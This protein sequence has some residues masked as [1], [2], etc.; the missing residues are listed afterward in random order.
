MAFRAQEVKSLREY[1]PNQSEATVYLTV[2]L[3]PR[4]AGSLFAVL[5]VF[6]PR[7]RS[8]R[9]D[10]LLE[11]WARKQNTSAV[12]SHKQSI[13]KTRRRITSVV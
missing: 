2:H 8:A 12:V 13:G 5:L 11:S 6:R 3:V 1:Q 9:A 7:S 4:A 10:H